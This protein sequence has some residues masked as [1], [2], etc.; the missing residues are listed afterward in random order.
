MTLLYDAM[1]L[2]SEKGVL[3]SSYKPHKLTGRYSGHWEC[4]LQT[5]WLLVWKTDKLGLV[6]TMTATGTHSDLLK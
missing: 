6:L 2:L 4:H 1:C 5:D 3:P